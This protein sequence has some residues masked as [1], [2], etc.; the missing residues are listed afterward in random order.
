MKKSKTGGLNSSYFI[1]IAEAIT[2]PLTILFKKTVDIGV[3][4]LDWKMAIA[5][6]ILNL[7]L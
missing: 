1:L 4:P 5:T 6:A 3:V 7:H 2:L